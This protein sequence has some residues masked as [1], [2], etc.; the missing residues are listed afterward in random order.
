MARKKLLTESEI[1]R[2][3]KLAS[4]S[5]V[6]DEKIQEY[7]MDNPGARDEEEVELGAELEDVP[8]DVPMDEPM[9]E[10]VEDEMDVGMEPELEDMLAK[11]VEALAAAWGIEDRVDV[12][13]DE[14]A[15]L[16]EPEEEAPL[17]GGDLDEL[18]A[19]MPE[20]DS[21]LETG[22]G[23]EL[24]GRR[25]EKFYENQDVIVKEVAKR[26]A[27]RLA[28]EHKKTEMIDTLTERIFKRLT[29]KK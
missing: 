3:M 10:P 1:R 19:E 15:A 29:S 2:F 14:E 6:G 11:G 28:K 21:V 22:V 13:G 27:A 23:D 20:D 9:D 12:E 25:D 7:G 17:E 16:E 26:V 4:M 18:P 5:P 24:P 8:M